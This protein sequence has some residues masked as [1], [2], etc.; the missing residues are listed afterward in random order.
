MCAVLG[1]KAAMYFNI[2][3]FRTDTAAVMLDN[4][5]IVDR[6]AYQFERGSLRARA[7]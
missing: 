5:V 7:E 1:N 4:I 6:A 3:A 2:C